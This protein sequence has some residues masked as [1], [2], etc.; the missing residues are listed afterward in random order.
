MP[1]RSRSRRTHHWRIACRERR[2][3]HRSPGSTLDEQ[4]WLTR[5]LGTT[6]ADLLLDLHNLYANATNFGF[7]APEVL[8]SIPPERIRFIHLAGGAPVRASN[9]DERWLDDHLHD[10]PDP[11]YELLEIVGETVPHGVDVVLERDGAF[12]PFGH[13]LAQLDRARAA[14]ARG[15]TRQVAA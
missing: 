13:L 3:D 7:S 4:T 1:P 2:D 10:V 11:V 14:L 9:G 5:L 8:R 12:P 15:R 6:R